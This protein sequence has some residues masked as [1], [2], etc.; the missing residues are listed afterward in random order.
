M[1]F[2]QGQIAQSWKQL[3]AFYIRSLGSP[4]TAFE[5]WLRHRDA[6]DKSILKPALHNLAASGQNP[7]PAADALRGQAAF[8]LSSSTISNLGASMCW[9]MKATMYAPAQMEKSKA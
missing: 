2:L 7:L 5:P 1:F 8:G 9:R 6:Q 4:E 3:Q